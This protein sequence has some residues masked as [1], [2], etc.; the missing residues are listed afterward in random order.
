MME[1]NQTHEKIV[2]IIKEKGPSLPI[3]IAKQLD[4]SS[5]FISA[6]LSELSRQKRIKIS[7]LKVGGSPLYFIEGQKEQLEPF[8]KYLHP[9]EA[10]AFLLLKKEGIL[11]DSEQKPAIRVALRSIRDFSIGFKKQDEIFWRYFSTPETEI[12]K[13]IRPKEEIKKPKEEDKKEK[14][15]PI[16]KLKQPI[17]NTKETFPN[18]LIIKQKPK[19]EKEKSEFVKNIIQILSR[20]EVV[21][22]KNYKAKEYNCIIQIKSELGTINFLTQAKDKKTISETDLKKLLSNAQ[23]IPLSAFLLYTGKLSK[24]ALEFTQTYSSVLKTK[25]I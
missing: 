10:E 13:T 2:N 7:H 4:I 9:R 23:S 5:L 18:P 11:K 24:K 19:K 20:F 12:T 17:K 14:P 8:H 25:K 1:I 22:E 6:F 3:Q 15:K 16:K 21:E